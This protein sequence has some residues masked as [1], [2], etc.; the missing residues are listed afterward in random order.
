MLAMKR[1]PDGFVRFL[2]EQSEGNP[3]FVPDAARVPE[4]EAYMD[5]LRKSGESVGARVNVVASGV[6]VGWGEPIYDRLVATQ[7]D[8]FA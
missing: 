1:A 2:T 4:L 5:Q 3:F 8:M 6:P 7:P